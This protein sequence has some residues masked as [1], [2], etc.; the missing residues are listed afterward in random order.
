MLRISLKELKTYIRDAIV[1][2]SDPLMLDRDGKIVE[3]DVRDKIKTYLKK[4]GLHQ[5]KDV[6]GKKWS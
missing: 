5:T 2:T 6:P 4:M 1:E 3:P